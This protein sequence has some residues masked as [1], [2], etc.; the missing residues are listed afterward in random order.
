M[1]L[2]LG[3]FFWSTVHWICN[4]AFIHS[5]NQW[6]VLY[7]YDSTST[8]WLVGCTRLQPALFIHNIGVVPVWLVHLELSRPGIHWQAI[9]GLQLRA[10]QSQGQGY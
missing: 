8:I 3:M 10:L 7:S 1:V 4:L 2:L 6:L 9:V 5:S